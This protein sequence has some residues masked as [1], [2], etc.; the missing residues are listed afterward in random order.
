MDDIF[1]IQ[2]LAYHLWEKAGYPDGRDQDFWYEA[3]KVIRN[4]KE[5][6]LEDDI[7][8]T[9]IDVQLNAEKT[10]NLDHDFDK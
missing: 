6:A 10:A 5:R 4:L 2:R 1:E 8:R 3:E 9:S 7:I